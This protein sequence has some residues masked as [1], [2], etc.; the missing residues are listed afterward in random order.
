[1]TS[2]T[3]P[4]SLSESIYD[5]KRVLIHRLWVWP[6]SPQFNGQ[7]SGETAGRMTSVT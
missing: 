7:V 3:F 4:P 5:A 6:F 1:M 2:G